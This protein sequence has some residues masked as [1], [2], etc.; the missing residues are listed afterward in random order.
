[1]HVSI[2][3]GSLTMAPESGVRTEAYPYEF[4]GPRESLQICNSVRIWIHGY[5]YSRFSVK[6]TVGVRPCEASS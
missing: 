4:C 2:G 3:A 5:R 1:M 6:E